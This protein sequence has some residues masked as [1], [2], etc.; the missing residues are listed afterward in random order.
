MLRSSRPVERST[1]TLASVPS[2]SNAFFTACKPV[3][4][5]CSVFDKFRLMQSSC[6]VMDVLGSLAF[7]KS[8]DTLDSLDETKGPAVAEHLR[9][10][11]LS[12]QFP[13]LLPLVRAIGGYIPLDWVRAGICGR[14]GLKRVSWFYAPSLPSGVMTLKG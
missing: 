5:E 14:E 11:T 12:G 13:R 4:L 9:L 7:S 3:S 8:F 10:A 6:S 1:H 2:S